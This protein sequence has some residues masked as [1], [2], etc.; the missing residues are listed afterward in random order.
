MISEARFWIDSKD[1]AFDSSWMSFEVASLIRK[2]RTASVRPLG[3]SA[4]EFWLTRDTSVIDTAMESL[5]ALTAGF[6]QPPLPE[7]SAASEAV[8]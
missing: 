3:N 4:H 2:V 8:L 5:T 6:S 1:S 7:E